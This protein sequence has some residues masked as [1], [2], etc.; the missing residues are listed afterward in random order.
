[1]PCR[2]LCMWIVASI[3]LTSRTADRFS[4]FSFALQTAGVTP[5]ERVKRVSL[6]ECVCQGVSARKATPHSTCET[7]WLQA[8]RGCHSNQHEAHRGTTP[9]QQP[10]GPASHPG[11]PTLAQV[12]A[13]APH[14]PRS[15]HRMTQITPATLVVTMCGRRAL[16]AC[17]STQIPFAC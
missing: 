2:R 15:S 6:V 3:V 7:A 8:R 17:A 13:M 5:R 1:L 9:L 10:H 14:T 4:P 12:R 16:G 11:P